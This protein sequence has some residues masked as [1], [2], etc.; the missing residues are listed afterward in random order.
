M[1][2]YMDRCGTFLVVS[3]RIVLCLFL[4]S[5]TVNVRYMCTEHDDVVFSMR[6]IVLYGSDGLILTPGIRS[7]V[8]KCDVSI[9]TASKTGSHAFDHDESLRKKQIHV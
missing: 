3:V 4:S 7:K 8:P 5:L 2:F 1:I 6:R 9:K